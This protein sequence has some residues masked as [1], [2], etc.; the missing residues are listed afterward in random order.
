MRMV[1]CNLIPGVR[2]CEVPDRHMHPT[3]NCDYLTIKNMCFFFKWLL[4][5]YLTNRTVSNFF[6]SYA[7]KNF[8]ET[9]RAL[10]KFVNL[11][12]KIVSQHM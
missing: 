1:M 3:G 2:N 10:R 4:S 11:C 8:T 7:V 12:N 5:C 9:L 6:L